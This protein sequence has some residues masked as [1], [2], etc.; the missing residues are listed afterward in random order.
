M[1]HRISRW[2][3][4]LLKNPYWWSGLA[5]LLVASA[6]L[7][8]VFDDV[9]MPRYTRHGVSTTLGNVEG[10]PYEVARDELIDRGL[11][12]QR[13]PGRY[14]P[15]VPLNQVVDQDPAPGSNVKPG[16]RVYLTVN[17]GS[18]RRIAVPDVL[19]LSVRNA[20]NELRAAGLQVDSVLADTIPAANVGTITRQQPTPGDT[21]D[22][23]TGVRLWSAQGVGQNRV[24]IPNVYGLSIERA[25]ARLLDARL[26]ATVL[27]TTRSETPRPETIEPGE[28][29]RRFVMGQ[30][31]LPGKKL[32][33]GRDVI[34]YVTTDSLR[35][36]RARPPAADSTEQSSS[37]EAPDRK[38]VV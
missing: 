3:V 8:V 27:D 35:A 23:G 12:V 6:V 2:W 30:R 38:S 19:T 37:S 28:E 31:P 32:L 24:E 13:Q 21:V 26:R 29:E 15:N 33:A 34:L 25:R 18:A 17:S 22:A 9:L 20:A 10:Q 11:R 36:A 14:N 5:A 4:A 16:R 7:Y 1:L